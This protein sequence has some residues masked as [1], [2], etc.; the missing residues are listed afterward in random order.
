MAN[1]IT[2]SEIE[3]IALVILSNTFGL[4]VL[5]GSALTQTDTTKTMMVKLNSNYGFQELWIRTPA[6]NN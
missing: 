2:L 3:Q 6:A 5:Y 4:I 1:Y